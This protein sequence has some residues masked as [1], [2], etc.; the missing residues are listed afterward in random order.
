M[1]NIIW[2]NEKSEHFVHSPTVENKD[3]N[4]K[5]DENSHIFPQIIKHT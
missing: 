5:W 1:K 4:G 3:W 2:N